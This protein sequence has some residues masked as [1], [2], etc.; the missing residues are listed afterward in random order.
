MLTIVN[1]MEIT[2]EIHGARE[3]G[4]EGPPA[5]P[6]MIAAVPG[7]DLDQALSHGVQHSL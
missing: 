7:L 2:M 6:R 5:G 4:G 1:F 3:G